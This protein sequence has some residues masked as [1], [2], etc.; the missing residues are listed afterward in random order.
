[1]LISQL[2]LQNLSY[3]VVQTFILIV[4]FIAFGHLLYKARQK[5]SCLPCLPYGEVERELEFW[6]FRSLGIVFKGNQDGS[7]HAVHCRRNCLWV[8]YS[9]K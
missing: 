8:L 2:L 6:N 3:F 4:V 7:H 1:M 9:K 5:I